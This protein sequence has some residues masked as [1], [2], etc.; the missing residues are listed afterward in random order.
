MKQIELT[1]ELVKQYE[2]LINK[3]VGQFYHKTLGTYGDIKSAAYLGFVQ[4]VHKYDEDR[5]NMTFLSFAAFEMR[6][7]IMTCLTNESRIV[8]LPFEEQVRLKSEGKSTYNG[9]SIDRSTREEDEDKTPRE[10]VMG[11]YEAAKF[12]DGDVF[13]YLYT[14]LESRFSE[15]DCKM[16]YMTYGLKGYEE[17]PNKEIAKLLCLSEGRI[18][19]RKNNIIDYIRKNNELCEMLANLF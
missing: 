19:Q 8:K 16:F 12:D 1:N 10:V 15:R 14:S 13:E 2:P 6:N 5:S 11:V 9:V 18:S 3:I 7:T 4:A 17:T